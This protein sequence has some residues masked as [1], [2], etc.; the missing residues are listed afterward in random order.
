MIDDSKFEKK[1]ETPTDWRRV[2][3]GSVGGFVGWLLSIPLVTPVFYLLW[4]ED[5]E[6]WNRIA[7]LVLIVVVASFCIGGSKFGTTRYDR[8]TAISDGGSDS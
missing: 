3:A 5:S 4:S 6:W 1:L 8:R 2:R 7:Q